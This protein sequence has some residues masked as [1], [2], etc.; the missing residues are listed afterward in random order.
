MENQSLGLK[1]IVAQQSYV[2][3]KNVCFGLFSHLVYEP[4]GSRLRFVSHPY[5]SV[6]REEL[7]DLFHLD[8]EAFARRL[9]KCSTY[10][11]AVNGNLLMEA[12][13]SADRQFAALRLLQWSQ[14]DY[15]PISD[16]HLLHGDDAAKAAKV[17]SL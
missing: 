6:V 10:E 17:F 3:Q 15:Q 16:V 13:V 9:S 5:G 12:C 14:I 1:Q 2:A 8:D 4:T 11:Q 7:K